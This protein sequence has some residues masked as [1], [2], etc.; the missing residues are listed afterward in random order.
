MKA[1]RWQD[2]TMLLLGVWLFASPFWLEGYS[3]QESVAAVNSYILGVLVAVFA[4]MALATQRSWEEWIEG[5]LGAWLVI[6]PF[7]LTFY[8]S[9]YGAALNHIAV[10]LL[11]I[12]GALWALTQHPGERA[13]PLER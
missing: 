1:Q 7:V 12:V 2:T 13:R 4:V 11:I 6:S 5:A 10:G 8:G 9:E 3:S